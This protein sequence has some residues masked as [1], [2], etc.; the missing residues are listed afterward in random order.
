M[1]LRGNRGYPKDDYFR[2]R[3]PHRI[4]ALDLPFYRLELRGDMLKGTK[5]RIIHESSMMDIILHTQDGP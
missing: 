1:G 4:E 2:A 3:F 5:Q